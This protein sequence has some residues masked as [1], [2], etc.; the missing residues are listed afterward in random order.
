METDV[1]K[2]PAAFLHAALRHPYDSYAVTAT[3]V[4]RGH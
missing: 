2:L 3:Y 4:E 1:L